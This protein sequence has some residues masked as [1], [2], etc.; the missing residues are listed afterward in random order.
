M[1]PAAPVTKVY[2]V[3]FLGEEGFRGIQKRVAHF[4]AYYQSMKW[5]KSLM[6]SAP[7]ALLMLVAFFYLRFSSK[8]QIRI[9]FPFGKDCLIR[10]SNKNNEKTIFV[11]Q[12]RRIWKYKSGIEFRLHEIHEKYFIDYIGLEGVTHLLDIGSNIGEF[13]L[14]VRQNYPNIALTLIEPERNEAFAARQNLPNAEVICAVLADATRDVEFVHKNGSGDSHIAFKSEIVRNVSNVKSIS[15]DQLRGQ[16]VHS[17]FDLIKIE[18]EGWE[19]EVTL[20]GS[21]VI[22]EAKYVVIDGSAER[23]E[24]G[25]CRETLSMCI[26]IMYQYGFELIKV[27]DDVGLF[28]KSRA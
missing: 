13:S 9:S 1:N 5:K 14:C 19:P 24:N 25:V 3:S 18:V 6:D 4:L 10:V 26:P 20:G 21:A 2:F 23:L 11:S 28:S 12:I 17:R 27:R 15:L 7:E 16:M 22:H 8:W